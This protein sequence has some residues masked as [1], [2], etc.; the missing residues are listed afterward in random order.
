MIIIIISFSLF[1]IFLQAH[2]QDKDRALVLAFNQELNDV[3]KMYAEGHLDPP[4]H[5]NMPPVVSKLMWI[6]ALK[7]RIKVWAFFPHLLLPV[8]LNFSKKKLQFFSCEETLPNSLILPTFNAW[9]FNK[10]I[11][12]KS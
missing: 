12:G 2:L 8:G 10:N 7:E 5:S 6:C 4:Q 9:V 3:R 1:L 11:C